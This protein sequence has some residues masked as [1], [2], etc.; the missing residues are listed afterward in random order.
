M[1]CDGIKLH[2]NLLQSLIHKV[3]GYTDEAKAV[4]KER[5]YV[6]R[7]EGNENLAKAAQVLKLFTDKSIA[8][9]TPW[10]EVR[11][12]A[13][14]ILEG[15]KL[16]AVAAHMATKAR[17]DEKAFRGHM[18]CFLF[19]RYQKL[20]DNLLQSLIHK[21]RGYTD[22]AKAVAKERVYVHRIEG[23][24]NLAKAAQVL[25]LFTDKSIAEETPWAEVR[26]K[27]FAILEGQKLDAVAA[28]M[29]TKARFD[30]KAFQW[31]HI[32]KVHLQFKRQLRPLLLWVDWASSSPHDPLI[33]AI[34]FLK[35]ALGQGKPLSQYPRETF[36]L[37]FVPSWP[38]ALRRHQAP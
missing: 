27:A 14:A 38:Y 3:R 29:A 34:S 17:F 19:H 1:R 37:Q 9:E 4:A 6:H 23:N 8:E 31:E 16:D 28:H 35:A 12:K 13:F 7:I 36:P 32:D 26:A 18:L 24:E 22:E 2:D 15:Q 30:E 33:E 5:V 10:A 20:H 21:V 25:K 11:A